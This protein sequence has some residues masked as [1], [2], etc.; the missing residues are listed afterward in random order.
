M[1]KYYQFIHISCNS[2]CII[3]CNYYAVV[4]KCE[5]RIALRTLRYSMLHYVRAVSNITTVAFDAD[6]SLHVIML[7]FSCDLIVVQYNY[8]ICYKIISVFPLCLVEGTHREHVQL[9]EVNAH[10]DGTLSMLN[11]SLMSRIHN[12]KSFRG[13]SLILK[14]CISSDKSA[15]AS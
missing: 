6:D 7:W 5:M 11:M 14:G 12:S 3:I 9:V 8:H 15:M 13:R 4:F 10:V 2:W 1:I